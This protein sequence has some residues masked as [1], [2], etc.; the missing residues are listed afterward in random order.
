MDT[1]PALPPKRVGMTGRSDL[2]SRGSGPSGDA[3][4]GRG[5][6]VVAGPGDARNPSRGNVSGPTLSRGSGLLLFA[7]PYVQAAIRVARNDEFLQVLESVLSMV[8]L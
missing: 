3:Q 5:N 6:V 8:S 7:S 2:T 4:L 1:G